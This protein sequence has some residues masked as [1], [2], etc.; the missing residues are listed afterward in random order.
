MSVSPVLLGC[1]QGFGREKGKEGGGLCEFAL[2]EILSG[3]KVEERKLR[4]GVKENTL[5]TV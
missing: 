1:L 5:G 2:G 3:L 4:L